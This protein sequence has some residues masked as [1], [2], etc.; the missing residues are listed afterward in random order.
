MDAERAREIMDASKD[1]ITSYEDELVSFDEVYDDTQRRRMQLVSKLEKAVDAIEFEKVPSYDAKSMEGT[2]AIVS[3]YS[4]LL[5]DS[6]KHASQR[7]NVKYKRKDLE[8]AIDAS[9][10]VAEY[11]RQRSSRKTMVGST[12]ATPEELDDQFETA[13]V[14]A[15]LTPILDTELREDPMDLS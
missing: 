14:A 15:Q 5:E 12:A 7:V 2:M 11:L 3:T 9:A 13:I 6:E 8:N 1:R 10:T 4:K